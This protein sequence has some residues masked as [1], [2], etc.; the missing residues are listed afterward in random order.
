M[1][2]IRI[3]VCPVDLSPA[4]VRQVD[5]AA[6][7]CRTFGARLVIHHTV[8]DVSVGA[9]VGW[10]WHA[11]HAAPAPASVE[12]RLRALLNG[13][14]QDLEVETCITHGAVT[15]AV[16]TVSD[17]AEADLIVLSA[18]AGKT[19][20]HA[21]VIEYLLE[22]SKRSVLALHDADA[23]Q[24][25]QA[26]ASREE[27]SLMRGLLV[28]TNLTSD[29]HT[30]VDFACDLA[31]MFPLRLHLLHV[32]PDHLS[33]PDRDVDSE[34]LT[35]RL[36]ALVPDDLVARTTVQVR[37]GDP[38]P[39]IVQSANDVAASCIVMGEHTRVPVKRWLTHDTARAVLHE[40]PCPVWYV[41]SASSATLSLS[42]L[43]LSRERSILWGNV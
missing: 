16:L 34:S 9:G 1:I 5:F 15:E 21:S 6:D 12:D 29:T 2:A 40:A 4:T 25:A 39:M 7:V 36:E 37:S 17:V 38:V 20:D 18:H 31:R 24:A 3:V 19:E 22:H 27:R 10:M 13:L 11:D 41:P 14:P 28:P 42:R 8:H 33:R 30:Q 35:A 26:F 32:T 23:K 43:A